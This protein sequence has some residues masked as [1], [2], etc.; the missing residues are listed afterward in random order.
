M[1]L[2]L[3]SIVVYGLVAVAYTAPTAPSSGSTTATDLVLRSDVVAPVDP[4][5]DS[6]LAIRAKKKKVQSAKCSKPAD[7]SRATVV[8]TKAQVGA[9]VSELRS[10]LDAR[11]K[12]IKTTTT[13]GPYPKVFGNNMK[14]T[15]ADDVVFKNAGCDLREYPLGPDPSDRSKVWS[16]YSGNQAGL[17]RVV[18]KSDGSFRGVMQKG[19]GAQNYIMC[20]LVEED[21]AAAA[22]ATTTAA[23]LVEDETAGTCS[24]EEAAAGVV[25]AKEDAAEGA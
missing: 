8:F 18:T 25:A 14:T 12:T 7:S 3:K 5:R 16:A 10:H 1:L 22:T 11:A 9:A 6:I 23:D 2:P 4:V 21:A 24:A 19:A 13:R 15:G 20:E 17:Y